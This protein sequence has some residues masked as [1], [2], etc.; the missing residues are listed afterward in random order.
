MDITDQGF[1][2]ASK[3]NPT[4]LHTKKLKRLKKSLKKF[5]KEVYLESILKKNK[6]FYN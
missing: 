1:L 3:V 6:N 2:N 4:N 5:I